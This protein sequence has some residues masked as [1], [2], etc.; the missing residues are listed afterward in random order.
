MSIL[1]LLINLKEKSTTL[2][3]I[4]D[5][6]MN[7]SLSSETGPFLILESGRGDFCCPARFAFFAVPCFFFVVVFFVMKIDGPLDVLPLWIH[8]TASLA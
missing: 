2:P 8:Y 6:V 1:T 5:D 7:L 3:L 4:I